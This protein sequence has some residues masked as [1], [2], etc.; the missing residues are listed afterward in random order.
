MQALGRH[1][2]FLEPESLG[3]LAN[4]SDKAQR[5]ASS[6]KR[7]AVIKPGGGV[8]AAGRV[9]PPPLLFAGPS[10]PWGSYQL[11]VLRGIWTAGEELGVKTHLDLG[12]GFG[13]PI[14]PIIN[15]FCTALL[16]L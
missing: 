5:F 16:F 12:T 8:Q 15:S 1:S 3:Q 10:S 14:Q 9:A 7:L 13:H 2:Y 4:F 6:C 11:E